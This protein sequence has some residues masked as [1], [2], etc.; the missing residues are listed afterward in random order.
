MAEMTKENTNTA[1]DYRRKNRKKFTRTVIQTLLLLL[2]IFFLYQVVFNSKHY[3]EPVKADW[4]NT[5]GF[6][7]LSY[8]GVDRTGSPKLVSKEQLEKQLGTLY[9]QGYKT[10]SQQDILDFYQK[11]KALPKKAL[12]LSFED[13]RNDSSIYAQPLLEKYNFKA[14]FFSYANKMGNSDRKFV[15]PKDMLKMLKTGYWEL[16]SN[17]YRLS[18]INIFDNA[19]N[20]I[21]DK[22]ENQLRNKQNIEYYNHYLMDFKRDENMIPTEH[23]DEMEKRIKKDYQLMKDIYTEQLGF[24]PNTYMI[25]HANTLYEGMNPLVSDANDENIKQ[26]FKMHFNR[27]GH[28]YNDSEQNL[29]DLTRVQPEPFWYTNHLLMRLNHDSKQNLQ[30]ISGDEEQAGKW[31]QLNG[32]AEFIDNRI[33]LTST[34]GGAGNIYLKD[35]DHYKDTQLK[36]KLTGN[37]VGQQKIYLRND[38]KKDAFIRINLNNNMLTVEEKK[39]GEEATELFSQ[40]LDT[41]KWNVKD[42]TF[43]KATYYSKAQTQSGRGTSDEDEYPTNIKQTRTFNITV[44]GDKLSLSVGKKQLISKLKIDKEIQ[45]G[46]ISLESEYNEQ[47]KKDDIYDGVFE[48]LEVK[49]LEHGE[50][51]QSELFTNKPSG[52]MKATSQIKKGFDAVIDWAIVTF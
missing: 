41:V 33:A 4:Q 49:N 26:L 3:E 36:V 22:N 25:M 35:S 39:E 20:Y 32:A 23:R 21:G 12:F 51:N 2:L 24:V 19:G 1:L 10:I 40:K 5:S 17:G 45:R 28:A 50:N 14:T 30:F 34:V 8:F 42:L 31:K 11:G 48:D 9:E 18:Y 7:A 16:G 52:M 15:Q 46:G 13:G 29:Y 43:E 37:V 6:I 27:E 44:K 38:L 47:N